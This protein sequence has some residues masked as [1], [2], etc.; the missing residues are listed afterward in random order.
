MMMTPSSSKNIED[1]LTY[2]PELEL[3]RDDL[4]IICRVCIPKNEMTS[5]SI[6]GIVLP[7][8]V[9]LVRESTDKDTNIMSRAFRNLKISVSRHLKRDRHQAA[10]SQDEA[11]NI[12][13][14]KESSRNNAIALKIGRAC[15]KLYYRGRLYTDYEDEILL[16]HRCGVDVG[17]INHSYKFSQ[18]YLESVAEVIKD[19][20]KGYL[21]TPL[22]QT[23]FPPPVKMF[24]SK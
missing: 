2:F 7:A 15:Y 16:L 4:T 23:G 11:Q 20:V 19:K 21:K 3:A 12:K 1:I 22:P 14:E 24:Q 10:I 5:A 18:K 17:D 13:I 8:G 6:T 9:F